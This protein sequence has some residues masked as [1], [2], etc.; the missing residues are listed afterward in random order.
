[1]IEIL[2]TGS[3]G[4]AYIIREQAGSLLLDGGFSYKTLL[5]RSKGNLPNVMLLS[6]RHSPASRGEQEYISHRNKV[7][8]GG[9]T[10]C[11]IDANGFYIVLLEVPHSVTCYSYI[12]FGDEEAYLY[13]TDTT[14]LPKLNGMNYLI[15]EC[16]Y[17]E[18]DI[19]TDKDIHL[20]AMESHMSLES[21]LQQLVGYDFSGMKEIILINPSKLNLDRDRAI[22]M[23]Q[24]QTGVVTKMADY[25]GGYYN[26]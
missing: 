3:S 6:H 16:N 1:M 12:I 15:V 17:S 24:K 5:R 10:N 4:S 20:K 7:Y 9:K 2:G 14:V 18:Q 21:L 8:Y 26:G 23:V 13:V 25:K 22:A 19:T 11:R